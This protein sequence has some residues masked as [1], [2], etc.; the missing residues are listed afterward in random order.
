[1]STGIRSSNVMCA[2][3][4]RA[5]EREREEATTV[6][7][8]RLSHPSIHPSAHMTATSIYAICFSLRDEMRSEAEMKKSNITAA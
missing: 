5:R 3:R 4:A 7:T 2:C 8:E 1:M 6:R